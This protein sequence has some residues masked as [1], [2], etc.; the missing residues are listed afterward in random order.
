MAYLLRV[1]VGCLL[2]FTGAAHALLPTETQYQGRCPWPTLVS[3]WGNS[4]EAICSA[5]GDACAKRQGVATN[6]AVWLP[7]GSGTCSLQ[8]ASGAQLSA[9]QYSS[10]GGLCPA[11][12]SA[13]TGGCQCSAGYEED[14]SHTSCVPKKSEL[15]QFCQDNAALKNGFN[16]SG[17]VA[18]ASQ[19]PNASCYKPYPPFEGAD[20]G[21]G[22]RTTLGDAVGWLGDD[23]KKHWSSTG[24][25]T[26]QTCEDAAA[27]DEAP[28]SA[29]DP[30]PS[31]FPGTVNGVAKCIAVEPDKGIEGVKG[32]SQTNADGTKID[33]K[34]TTKCVASV[35][36]TTTT[37]TTTTVTGSTSTS[38]SS[39]TESIGDKCEK[40][41]KNK[42]CQKT[43]GGTGSATSQMGC[44][45]NSSAEG[46]GGEGSE[47]G[48]LYGKKD[49]TIAQVMKKASDDLKAAPLGSAVGGFFTVGSGGTCPS[50]SGVVPFL[51]KSV[52]F[53]MFCTSFAA[54]MFLIVRMVLLMLATWMAFRVA[55]DH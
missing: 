35:C 38:T 15:E 8:N 22:C 11:N 6:K 53:D 29:P 52:T 44:E 47:I 25:M 10:Q 50:P 48:E 9:L 28:K 49:K 51:N 1:F 45:Q 23:G 18:P 27:T 14:A 40:D 2:L 42:V 36:T 3:D 5:I 37:T 17:T 26:G 7:A 34:E 54:Q 30:C 12:S 41:P 31:G 21:K 46:C 20:A 43:Q 19:I 39:R 32:T 33:S 16:Q 4:K 13:V 55:I 24:V